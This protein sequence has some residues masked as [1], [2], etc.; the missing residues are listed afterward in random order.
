MKEKDIVKVNFSQM[1]KI[2][3]KIRKTGGKNYDFKV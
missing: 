2:K 3:F 1:R